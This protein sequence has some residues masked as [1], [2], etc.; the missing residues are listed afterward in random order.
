MKRIFLV[1]G[2]AGFFQAAAQQQDLFD[3]EKYL[4]KKNLQKKGTQEL[5]LPLIK[6]WQSGGNTHLHY[7]FKKFTISSFP[8]LAGNMPCIRPDMNQFRTM[9]NLADNIAVW[10]FKKK[11]PGVIPNP[12]HSIFFI[13]GK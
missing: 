7:N 6:N 11:G 8:N 5:Q 2:M 13:A 4:Q 9:P 10:D 1:F 12:A 3:V